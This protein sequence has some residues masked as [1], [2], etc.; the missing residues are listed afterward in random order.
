MMPFTKQLSACAW[1]VTCSFLLI[2]LTFH[3]LSLHSSYT[4]HQPFADYFFL[5]L[6]LSEL[7]EKRFFRS[8]ANRRLVYTIATPRANQEPTLS[9]ISPEMI[10]SAGPTATTVGRK[11][12]FG[13]DFLAFIYHQ[14]GRSGKTYRG[15]DLIYFGSFWN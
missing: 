4:I 7:F 9:T 5:R 10:S 11:C 2:N 13:P 3:N 15:L 6:P 14:L 1:V 8:R 12:T